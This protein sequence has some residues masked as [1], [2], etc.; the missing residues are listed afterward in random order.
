MPAGQGLRLDQEGPPADSR[1]ALREGREHKSIT[2][3]PAKLAVLP[4][5]HPD[6]VAQRQELGL[7]RSVIPAGP[8]GV[9][10]QPHAGVKDGEDHDDRHGSQPPGL[11]GVACLP[12]TD[13]LLAPYRMAS[14]TS[15]ASH[16]R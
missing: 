5:Q 10:Q 13:G 4:F 14:L 1:Q 16:T 12:T 9:Q 15:F 6:L 7:I 3:I 8:H 11:P 2:A